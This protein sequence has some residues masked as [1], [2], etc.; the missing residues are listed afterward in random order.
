MM[1]YIDVHTDESDIS[2]GFSPIC[3]SIFIGHVY[4]WR[5]ASAILLTG[6]AIENKGVL[7]Q[8]FQL[9][10]LDFFLFIVLFPLLK[11]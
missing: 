4:I 3:L 2:S 5:N 6:G 7:N 1:F 11:P 10:F 9:W 8:S